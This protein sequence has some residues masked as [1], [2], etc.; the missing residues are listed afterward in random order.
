[1]YDNK[2]KIKGKGLHFTTG[3][4]YG[5]RVLHT[6]KAGNSLRKDLYGKYSVTNRE[7]K[8]VTASGFRQYVK[9]NPSVRKHFP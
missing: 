9:S 5:D 2:L 3:T 4:S 8:T 6:D 7:G 1:M